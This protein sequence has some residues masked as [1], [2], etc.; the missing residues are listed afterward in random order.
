[1]SNTI[2]VQVKGLMLIAAN[3]FR[4]NTYRKSIE[5][6]L[7]EKIRGLESQTSSNEMIASALTTM[8]VRQ[9]SKIPYMKCL[10]E[11]CI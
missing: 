4:L 8:K 7:S 11:F 9:Y 10:E 6:L 5:E 2:C 3:S 1:M